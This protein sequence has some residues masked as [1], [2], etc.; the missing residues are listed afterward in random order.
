MPARADLR[1]PVST[2][3]ADRLGRMGIRSGLILLVLLLV[4]AVVWGLWQLKL[5]VIPLIIAMILAAAIGPMVNWLVK[6]GVPLTLA[7][8]IAFLGLLAVLSGTVALIAV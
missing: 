1:P 6:R 5:I 7:T 4:V 2:V 3:V 8:W